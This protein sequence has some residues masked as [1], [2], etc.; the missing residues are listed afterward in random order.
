[1]AGE[2][3]A[4]VGVEWTSQPVNHAEV[5]AFA[6]QARVARLRWLFPFT[7]YLKPDGSWSP[8]YQH[9]G[10]F[11]AAYRRTDP[12]TRLLA[13]VG[14]PTPSADFADQQMRSTLIAGIVDIVTDAGFDGVH[15]NAEPLPSGDPDFL[16]FLDGLR[17]ALPEE[18]SISVAGLPWVTPAEA[19]LSRANPFRWSGAYYR[20]VATRVD[21]LAVMAYDSH[22]PDPALYR[23][24][25]REQV[26]GVSASVAGSGVELLFGV[27]LSRE[28]T[29]LH[30]P[31]VESLADGL[32]GICADLSF[33]EQREQGAP[34][35]ALCAVGGHRSGLAAVAGRDGRRWPVSDAYLAETRASVCYNLRCEPEDMPRVWVAGTN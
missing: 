28:V 31:A 33:D 2:H 14:L 4:W 7:T 19:A 32:S 29:P 9:A 24:W 10:D 22:M 13:W 16:A 20:E 25:M 8:S 17:A 3:A 27:S 1:M 21:Q 11:V 6:E 26:R 12:D 5:R 15:L 35:V 18:R 34:G 30:N 23:L